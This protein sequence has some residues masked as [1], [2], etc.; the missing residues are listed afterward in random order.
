MW[1]DFV[2]WTLCMILID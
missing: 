2:D 1:K